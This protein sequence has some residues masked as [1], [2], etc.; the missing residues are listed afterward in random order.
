MPLEQSALAQ[1]G[2]DV[3]MI[4]TGETMHQD[5]AQLVAVAQG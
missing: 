2:E 5:A 1:H 4:A 3:A